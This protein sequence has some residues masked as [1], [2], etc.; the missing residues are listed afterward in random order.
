M[1]LFSVLGSLMTYLVLDLSY[2][3]LLDVS[4]F[5]IIY[6]KEEKINSSSNFEG[7]YLKL[8][9]K[10]WKFINSVDALERDSRGHLDNLNR[11][12]QKIKLHTNLC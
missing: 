4:I 12:T 7:L 8:R 5:T 1:N 9:R 6:E 3:F 2:I 10:F 11:T